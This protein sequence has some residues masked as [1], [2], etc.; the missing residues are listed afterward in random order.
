MNEYNVRG[1]GNAVG[2]N[3]HVEMT[4]NVQDG[5]AAERQRA[6]RRVN[7]LIQARDDNY[8]FSFLALIAVIVVCGGLLEWTDDS[9]WA[10]VLVGLALAT[11]V[12]YKAAQR[13]N[14]EALRLINSYALF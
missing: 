5:W 8:R 3:N 14:A 12:P 6:A 2:T 11:A 10:V 1:I 4:V 9:F 13:A 7:V